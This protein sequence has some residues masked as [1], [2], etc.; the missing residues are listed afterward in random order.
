MLG[1]GYT[2]SNTVNK[3]TA[4]PVEKETQDLGLLNRKLD[5]LIAIGVAQCEIE[6]PHSGAEPTNAQNC[7]IEEQIVVIDNIS[8]PKDYQ[9]S[10]VI[11]KELNKHSSISDNCDL[12]YGLAQ[13]GIAIHLK[14]DTDREK[15]IESWPVDIFGGGTS[16]HKTKRYSDNHK[17]STYIR[18]IPT[19]ISIQAIK[20]SLCNFKYKSVRRMRYHDTNQRTIGPVNAHLIS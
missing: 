2:E 11:N 1:I 14:K 10:K 13:G 3:Q 18:D 5:Q 6:G 20:D 17:V 7:Y 4:D 9:S 12:A 16:A 8:V 19:S 15:F